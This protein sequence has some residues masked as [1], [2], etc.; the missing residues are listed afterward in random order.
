MV[1]HCKCQIDQYF[2]LKKMIYSTEIS[3]QTFKCG[4]HHSY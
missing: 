2:A 1:F 3:F 4:M